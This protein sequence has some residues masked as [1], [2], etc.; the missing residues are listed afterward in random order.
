[1]IT[2]TITFDPANKQLTFGVQGTDDRIVVEGLLSM[3]QAEL[4][5]RFRQRPRESEIEVPAP[6]FRKRYLEG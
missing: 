5:E 1:M 3:A 2:L 6:P 4:R